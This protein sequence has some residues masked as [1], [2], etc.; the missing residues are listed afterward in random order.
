MRIIVQRL[1]V[2]VVFQINLISNVLIVVDNFSFFILVINPLFNDLFSCS[3]LSM[4]PLRYFTFGWKSKHAQPPAR[5]FT[6]EKDKKFCHNKSWLLKIILW[7]W[8]AK[9][10]NIS[11]VVYISLRTKVFFWENCDILLFWHSKSQ[12]FEQAKLKIHQI[13][14][15]QTWLVWVLPVAMKQISLI[16]PVHIFLEQ[17]W[18]KK[19]S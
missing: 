1:N 8:F 4:H 12:T 5:L 16:L 13:S 18:C 10:K 15:N 9:K 6:Q 7:I 2:F 3:A 11:I 17:F 19:I 14:Y